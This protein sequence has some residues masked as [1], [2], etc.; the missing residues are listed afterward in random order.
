MPSS[1]II[2]RQTASGPRYRVLYRLGGRESSAR[3]AGS[4]K[5]KAEATER[6]RWV[7]GELGAMR[8]P[9]PGA[10]QRQPEQAPT[11]AKVA[12]RWRAS[13]LDVSDGTRIFHRVALDRLLPLLGD[14][15]MDGIGVEDLNEAIVALYER[16]R[17]PATIRKSIQTLA[18][19]LSDYGVEPNVARDRR[20]RFPH[21]RRAEIKPPSGE[22]VGAVHSLLPSRYRL[23]LLALDATGMRV[24]ELEALTWGDVDEPRS[25][26]R[27][28]QATSKTRT[29]RWV[30]VP[31]AIFAAVLEL[32]P[33]EDRTAER[34]VFQGFGADRFRTAITRA[35]VASGT[36]AFSPHDLRH[37]RISLLHLAGVPWAR[38][39]EHVG[40]RNL[41]V[42]AN[43]YTHVLADEV[44]LDYSELLTQALPRG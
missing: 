6:R 44:E 33:R 42:T 35:C 1:W 31:P 10:L 14:R 20:L 13:R 37:R 40:Q 12:E 19:L 18:T 15:R 2:R 22:H 7:D 27:V 28:S 9:D 39:G 38:I 4:F 41:A 32:V 17:K 30:Q 25:R 36:P 29:A 11:L 3:Y 43:T 16:G 26:W 5:T 34:P 24:G 8:V 23:P 21:E